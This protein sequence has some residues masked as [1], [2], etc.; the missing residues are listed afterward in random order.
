MSNIAGVLQEAGTACPLWAPGFTPGFLVVVQK[1]EVK[2]N[3]ALFYMGFVADITTQSSQNKDI[4]ILNRVHPWYFGG[5]PCCSCFQFSVLR[6]CFVCLCL[7]SCIPNVV[8]FSG[9]CILD[10]SFGFL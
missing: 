6:F 10:C 5:G 9:L 8:S 7:V 2:T 4:L 3:R 1:L